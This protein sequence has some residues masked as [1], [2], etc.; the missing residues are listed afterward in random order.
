[1]TVHIYTHLIRR[2]EQLFRLTPSKAAIGFIKDNK[3]CS[4]TT[5]LKKAVKRF[6]LTIFFFS[7]NLII[8]SSIYAKISEI[9]IHFRYGCSMKA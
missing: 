7:H 8:Y 9:H 6:Q 5:T 2:D 1:M 3:T 4:N